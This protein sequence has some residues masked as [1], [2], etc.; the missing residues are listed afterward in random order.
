MEAPWLG[1]SSRKH[2]FHQKQPKCI[3]KG[4]ELFWNSPP[5]YREKGRCLSPGGFWSK[6]SKRT[7]ITKFTLLFILYGKVTKVFQIWFSSFFL[8]PFTNVKWNML[9]Q[10][11]RKFYGSITEAPKTIFQQCGGACRPVASSLSNPTSKMFWK[12]LDLNFYLH[13]SLDKFTPPFFCFW[14]FSFQNLR[15]HYGFHH[16]EC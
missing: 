5:I 13:P 15:K 12:G 8:F 3:A 2:I 14:P 4:S 10:G 11:F 1:F 9:T 16:D 7:P 6:I